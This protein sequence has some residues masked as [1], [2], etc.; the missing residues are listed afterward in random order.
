MPS[1]WGQ[2][3]GNA[4]GSS[5]GS[6]TTSE[7][8]FDK[9]GDLG[10]T[11]SLDDRQKAYLRDQGYSGAMS[12]AVVQHLTSLGYTVQGVNSKLKAKATAEGFSSV[13]EMM[14]KQGMIPL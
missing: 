2:S 3:W 7:R 12:G 13:N 6:V 11:G 10:Y 8:Y 1:A 9:L 5:W 14:R 4:W